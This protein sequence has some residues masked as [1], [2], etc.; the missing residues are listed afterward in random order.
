[1]ETVRCQETRTNTASL[2]SRPRLLTMK[3]FKKTLVSAYFCMIL[4]SNLLTRRPLFACNLCAF[5]CRVTPSSSSLVAARALQTPVPQRT[6]RILRLAVMDQCRLRRLQSHLL[7]GPRRRFR[8]M[9]ASAQLPLHP[10]SADR[11][12]LLHKVDLHRSIQSENIQAR[13]RMYPQS[14]SSAQR[15]LP[16]PYLIRNLSSISLESPRLRHARQLP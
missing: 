16:I 11:T 10:Q 3:G 7:R 9:A 1:M 2:C 4:A 5:C 14:L 12:R 15:C 6:R 8:A 13:T